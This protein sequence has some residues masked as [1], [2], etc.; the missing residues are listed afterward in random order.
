MSKYAR[1]VCVLYYLHS[2][3]ISYIFF[4]II[5]KVADNPKEVP[6]PVNK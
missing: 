6:V 2:F 3:K 5:L 1:I 4:T